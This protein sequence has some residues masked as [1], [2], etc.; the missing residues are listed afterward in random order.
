MSDA[1]DTGKST[2]SLSGSADVASTEMDHS[3][4]L[5][6]ETSSF[7]LMLVKNDHVKNNQMVRKAHIYLGMVIL[8]ITILLGIQI[9]LLIRDTCTLCTQIGVHIRVDAHRGQESD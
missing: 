3:D 1:T 5:G 7:M 8:G 4:P 6:V 9:L 2:M